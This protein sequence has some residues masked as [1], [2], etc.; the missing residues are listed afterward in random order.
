MKFFYKLFKVQSDVN[1]DLNSVQ[2]RQ[3]VE[4]SQIEESVNKGYIADDHSTIS[5][6]VSP[7]KPSKKLRVKTAK[8]QV[9]KWKRKVKTDVDNSGDAPINIAETKSDSIATKQR[10]EQLENCVKLLT[11]KLEKT[12]QPP[13]Q[14]DLIVNENKGQMN[15][16][17]DL[18]SGQKRQSMENSEIK[19]SAI[20]KGNIAD[21]H[22]NISVPVFAKKSKCKSN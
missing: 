1:N 22:N 4:N 2:K 13:V 14:H 11:E 19:E 18:I 8:K 12:S 5:D 20:N 16:N 9:P 21:N 6:P 7:K 17:K 10:V 15:D 3:S